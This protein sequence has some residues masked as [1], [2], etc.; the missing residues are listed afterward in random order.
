VLLFRPSTNDVVSLRNACAFSSRV[1]AYRIEAGGL[2][3]K[4]IFEHRR[5]LG[6]AGSR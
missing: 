5:G 6:K 2:T 3:A 4:L 1:V